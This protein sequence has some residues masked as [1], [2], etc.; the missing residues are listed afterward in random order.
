MPIESKVHKKVGDVTV[1]SKYKTP[2]GYVYSTPKYNVRGEQI[3]ST[4]IERGGSYNPAP[5]TTSTFYPGETAG[6]SLDPR[7]LQRMFEE[8]K[9]RTYEKKVLVQREKARMVNILQTRTGSDIYYT[10]DIRGGAHTRHIEPSGTWV[11]SLAGYTGRTGSVPTIKGM[12]KS[13]SFIDESQYKTG[14]EIWGAYKETKKK[15]R[16]EEAIGTISPGRQQKKNV[17]QQP[18]FYGKTWERTKKEKPT[19]PTGK[20]L[21]YEP[22]TRTTPWTAAR[23]EFGLTTSVEKSLV[24]GLGEVPAYFRGT[25][26][27]KEYKLKRKSYEDV[28]GRTVTG[29]G[30]LGA[31]YVSGGASVVLTPIQTSKGMVRMVTHPKESMLELGAQLK[32]SPL[33]VIGEFAGM[34]TAFKFGVEPVVKKVLPKGE[35]IDYSIKYETGD[36]VKYKG[37]G[38]GYKGIEPVVGVSRFERVV[39]PETTKIV[40]VEKY[41]LKT[42]FMKPAVDYLKTK[43]L[44]VK[45]TTQPAARQASLL[46]KQTVSYVGT[47][48]KGPVRTVG[49]IIRPGTDIVRTKMLQSK[50][51]G[52]LFMRKATSAAKIGLYVTESKLGIKR[53][54]GRI[55]DFGRT[56]K[57]GAGLEYQY[58]KRQVGVLGKYG[59]SKIIE[60]FGK[61]RRGTMKLVGGPKSYAKTKLL[62]AKL[63][64]RFVKRK[65]VTG[66]KIPVGKGMIK[67]GKLFGT[68]KTVGKTKLLGAKLTTRL[69]KRKVGTAIKIP[70]GKG[71]LKVG[72]GLRPVTKRLGVFKSGV[73]TRTLKLKLMKRFAVRD[74]GLTS[75][76][77]FYKY[78][79]VKYAGLKKKGIIVPAVI[80]VTKKPEFVTGTPSISLKGADVGTKGL[81]WETAGQT[82]I[83]RKALP[84]V[85]SAK[86]LKKFDS[87]L[88]IMK[89]TEFTK[90]KFM[91]SMQPRTKAT[92]VKGTAAV[93]KFIIEKKGL[94][95]GSLTAEAQMIKGLF[96]KGRGVRPGEVAVGDIDVQ[97]EVGDVKAQE[98]AK[99][100]GGI[101]KGVGAKVKVRKGTTLVET[102]VGGE[103]RHAVDIHSIESALED[104]ARSDIGGEGAYGLKF[105]QKPRKIDGVLSMPL[106]EYGLRKGASSLTFRKVGKDYGFAPEAHRL[107]DPADWF[108]AQESLIKSERF[109]QSKFLKELESVKGTHPKEIFKGVGGKG[110]KVVDI[111]LKPTKVSVAPAFVASPFKYS[112]PSV[113]SFGRGSYGYYYGVSASRY[114]SPSVY[115]SVSRSVSP[116]V[117]RSISPSISPSISKSISKSVSI[118][119]STSLS[120]SISKSISPSISPS[121]SSTYRPSPPP[122]SVVG[123]FLFDTKPRKMKLG[124]TKKLKPLRFTPKYMPS[125][126]AV[127]FGVK[128]FKMPSARSVAAGLDIRPIVI[129]R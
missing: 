53:G 4:V 108:P 40:S 54:A 109:G 79:P 126:E 81:I 129:R 16:P 61:V 18:T 35:V 47:K 112:S 52:R 104:A 25:A 88:K 30:I 111:P 115:S 50:L 13:G 106:S 114:Y 124:K 83:F 77:F 74:V 67:G 82:K 68:V 105:G 46:G 70:V 64:T 78:G 10:P 58:Y 119:I 2:G 38:V 19:R 110:F 91:R 6:T 72:K 43:K 127:A 20:D 85:V 118:S 3:G 73:K 32:T 71:M 15:L 28:L 12:K 80:E 128:S 94:E 5:K 29:F 125:L 102:K 23:K 63:T 84:E 122:K 123:G 42:G 99:E 9:K 62:G 113:R 59:V 76:Q 41:G 48:I 33:S 45:L 65:V 51:S 107:K 87:M 93:Q 89:H 97:F 75:K 1:I 27:R 60:P 34:A 31:S 57:L 36:V 92:G 98:Y 11:G 44:Q 103:Y 100:V 17:F 56:K 39:V 55:I 86:E 96:E 120:S 66:I 101:L 95:Y 90:S 14:G 37:Y 117:L 121:P 7:E 22:Y 8:T 26:E 116:S 21:R 24:K 69:A 49:D